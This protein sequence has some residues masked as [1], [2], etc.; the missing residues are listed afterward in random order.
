M[1]DEDIEAVD[2][3]MAFAG[4]DCELPDNGPEWDA[5]AAR[6]KVLRDRINKLNLRLAMGRPS[7]FPPK[8]QPV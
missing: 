3:I 5:M 1:S 2:S 6:V 8:R 4:L 7:H